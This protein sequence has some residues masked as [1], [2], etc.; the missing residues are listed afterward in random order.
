MAIYSIDYSN[1]LVKRLNSLQEQIISRERQ[2]STY[3]YFVNETPDIPYYD[4]EEIQKLLE[5]ISKAIITIKHEIRKVNMAEKVASGKTADEAILELTF[6]NRS[7]DKL[8]RMATEPQKITTNT[9][10]GG[11]GSEIRECNYDV[12]KANTEYNRV[13]NRIMQLQDELNN[14]NILHQIKIDIDVEK[15]LES[16]VF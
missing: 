14:F 11:N 13:Y 12:T 3:R 7:V 16:S 2:V 1:K 9:I 15:L 6:L 8:R 4:F 10:N 5:E